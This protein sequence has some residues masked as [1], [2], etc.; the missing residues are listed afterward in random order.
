MEEV[1]LTGTT[2]LSFFFLLA[3]MNLTSIF[4]EDGFWSLRRMSTHAVRRRSSLRDSCQ[5]CPVFRPKSLYLETYVYRSHRYTVLRAFFLQA[6]SSSHPPDV[7][8]AKKI[9]LLPPFIFV[10]FS[11]SS[12]VLLPPA[13]WEISTQLVHFSNWWLACTSQPTRADIS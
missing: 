10:F 7:G 13:A 3:V 1:S 8:K 6:T 12:L 2:M 5:P 4:K 11:L 9:L